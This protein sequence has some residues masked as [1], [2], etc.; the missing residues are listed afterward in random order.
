MFFFGKKPSINVPKRVYDDIIAHA[1]EA[2]PE[3]CC[4]VLVGN[5][6][7]GRK[8]FESHR[9]SNAN[10][11]RARDRYIIDPREINVIDKTAR[12][13][14]LDI[15]GFYHSHPDHPDR[16]SQFDRE[17]GQAG[18]SYF[19]VSVSKGAEV[20]LKS[21]V[22]EEDGEPFKEEAIKVVP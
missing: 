20:S 14:G 7:G 17:M 21:W 22:F 9:A 15:I 4:G 18:Y 11:E 10:T 12:V 19:I 5:V 2:Y 16:P 1:K 8:L 13:E 6:M 3:E